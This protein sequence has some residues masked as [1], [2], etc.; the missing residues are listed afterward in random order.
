M[1]I[2]TA[3]ISDHDHRTGKKGPYWRMDLKSTEGE[4]PGNI[5][6]IPDPNK[7][8][9]PR[10]GD[11]INIDLDH[12]GVKDQRE[13]KWGS[14]VF[15]LESYTKVTKEDL[16]KETLETIYAVAKATPEQLEN[17]Y[18]IITEK[19]MYK[20]T[21]NFLFVMNCLAKIPKEKLFTCPAGRSVH[22]AYQ[23]GLIVHTAEVIRICRGIVA[24][25]PFRQFISQ[26]VVFAG[27]TLHDIGK[28]ITYGNDELGQ[29][30][31]TVQETTIGHLYYGMSVVEQ[32]AKQFNTDKTFLSEVLHV[33]GSH[34]TKTEFGA[35]K[36][37]ATLEAMIVSTADYLGSRGGVI[38]AHLSPL[39]KKNLPL[40]EEWKAYD[41]RYVMGSA[42]K[43]WFN[44]K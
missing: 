31:A 32:V 44:A 33:I 26:D 23:G 19:S 29:P 10:K 42:I 27:A 30:M 12:K 36:E 38:E 16:P 43:E 6:D 4:F 15:E 8:D 34:H 1:K 7:V 21:N 41:Q 20:D 28:A 40:D 13:G 14:I 17:A 24:A 5:W 39:K 25:F 22:H 37:P 9:V 3:L 18:K 2:V 35:I 11:I